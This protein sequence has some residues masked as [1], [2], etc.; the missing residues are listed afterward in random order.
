MKPPVN[1]FNFLKYPYGDCTQWY[2]ENPKLYQTIGLASHNGVD[3]VRPHGEHLF[4]VEDGIVVDVKDDP[5]GYGKHIRLFNKEI[6]REWSYGHLHFIGVKQG[7]EVKAGQFVGLMGNTGFVV[8]GNTPYWKHNPYAGTHLHLGLREII[9]DKRGW[10]YKGSD[11]K[12]KTLNYSNGN[13]G[14]VDPLHFFAPQ[15]ALLVA[16][17]ADKHNDKLYWQLATLLNKINV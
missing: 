16:R 14:S 8:S 17:H 1:N 11:I 7:Q 4:A 13:K 10:S 12:I 3:I 15:R 6:T 9:S 2:G 5:K